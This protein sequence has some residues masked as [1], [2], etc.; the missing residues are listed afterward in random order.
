MKY[1]GQISLFPPSV[2]IQKNASS[3]HGVVTLGTLPKGDS[4]CYIQ[5][6]TANIDQSVADTADVADTVCRQLGYTSAVPHSMMT[7]NSSQ[8]LFGYSY[9]LN[10]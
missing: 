5:L 10:V 7:K 2:V 6:N 4:G 3:S 8:S 9:D 1:K